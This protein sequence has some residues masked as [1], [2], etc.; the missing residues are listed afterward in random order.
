MIAAKLGSAAVTA[1]SDEGTLYLTAKVNGLPL[2]KVFLNEA[3]A[4]NLADQVER[5]IAARAGLMVHTMA[6]ELDRFGAE[7][8]G[9]QVP[10]KIASAVMRA[11]GLNA[12]TEARRRAFAFTMMD[13]IG[14]LTRDFETIDRLDPGDHRLL[15]D[16]GITDSDWGVWRLAR[17]DS[18]RGN[19]T[20]LTPEAIYAIP[21]KDLVGL[22]KTFFSSPRLLKEQAA[23]K[24]L[25]VVLEEQ[26]IAVIE[27]GPRERVL[28]RA[29][30]EAGTVKGELTRSFFLFKSFPVAMI[31]RHWQRGL[32]MYS[33][34]A[35]KAGYLGTL[36]ATQTLLGALAMELNDI[37][38]GKDPRSLN[39]ASEGGGRNWMAAMLKG[40]SLGLYG[41]FLFVDTTDYGRTLLGALAGPVAGVVE[42]VDDLTRGNIMQAMRGE[43]THFGAELTR[44][45]RSNTPGGSLWY[46][47]AA[48]DRMIFHQLQEYF[49]PGYLDRSKDRAARQYGTSYWWEPGAPTD[50]RPPDLS[51]VTAE[52]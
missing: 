19:D 6:D 52:E 44:F 24:L 48:L 2:N 34:T 10:H 30:T 49:S 17:T 26:D 5:R 36:L 20:L 13:T 8:L 21:D 47:K 29:G 4:F 12:V 18:F 16:K 40:G 28:M 32:K 41:D 39:P 23:S 45:A 42:D 35:G 46:A 22:G 7:T 11:S 31:A 27:P 9:S 43:D 1:I 50:A 25:A 51:R 15:L 14:A 37:L 33:T 3:A 38:Q